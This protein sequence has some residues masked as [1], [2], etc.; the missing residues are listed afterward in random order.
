MS[1][2]KRYVSTRQT[3]QILGVHESSIKRWCNARLL[4]Y[5]LTEGG[6]RRLEFSDVVAF[7]RAES[8]DLPLLKFTTEERVVW[9]AISALQRGT[10]DRIVDLLYRWLLCNEP[11]RP[12]HLTDYLLDLG[13]PVVDLFDRVFAPVL[14]RVGDEWATGD[15]MTGD[16]HRMSLSVRD[17]VNR[18]RHRIP[19]PCC[20]AAAVVGCVPGEL[21]EL[22]AMMV[23]V[24]LES[25]GWS[26]VYLGADVPASQFGSQQQKL[27]A[28]LVCI[29][30]LHPHGLPD[31]RR[32]VDTL[33]RM[34]DDTAPFRL[35]FGG[36]GA[37][38]P[39]GAA[40]TTPFCVRAESNLREFM[41]WLKETESVTAERQSIIS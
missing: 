4:P 5:T 18:V 29:S 17:W 11:Y 16:E 8:M 25:A 26:V 7:A 3:A 23:R 1:A 27:K 2:S 13:T 36:G 12:L 32:V 21:H 33:T 24:V 10:F 39:A 14:H 28:D 20:H 19:H 9:D 35:V 30:L 31:A 15:I 38:W 41:T 40:G 37:S 6:H 22:G 34:Y